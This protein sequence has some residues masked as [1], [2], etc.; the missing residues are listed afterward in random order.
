MAAIPLSRRSR[1]LRPVLA[2]LAIVIL[3][4]GALM[5]PRGDAQKAQSNLLGDTLPPLPAPGFLLHDQWGHAVSLRQFRGRPVVLT[6][7]QSTCT[8]LCPVVAETIHRAILETGAAGK[9]LAVLAVS[10]DPE[11]DTVATARAFSSRHGLLHRWLYLMGSRRTLTPVWHAYHLYVAPANAPPALAQSHTSATYLID[12]R[13]RERVLMTGDP[14]TS[15]L[16]NDFRILLGQNPAASPDLQLAAPQPDHPA[17]G[18]ALQTLSGHQISLAH[19]RGKVVIVNFWATWCSACKSE[20]PRLSRWY[21]QMH[22]RGV[23]IVG[24]D[25]QEDPHSVSAYARRYHMP[26]PILL[27]GSGAVSAHYDV[28]FLPKSLIIDPRGVVRNVKL[29]ALVDSDLANH[30]VPLLTR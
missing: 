4:M 17:P 28:A 19:L 26:Y 8:Q 24:I 1:R 23:D 25:V 6:F 2:V 9:K 13:G 7:S 10:T 14:A 30:V 11:H 15:D 5:V 22:G 18:F 29:G 3:A 21:R 12:A 16:V 20:V 27:D